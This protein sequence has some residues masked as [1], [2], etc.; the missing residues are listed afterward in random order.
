MKEKNNL[1]IVLCTIPQPL[2]ESSEIPPNIAIV[3]LFNWMEKHGFHGEFYDIDRI[4]PANKSIVKYFKTKKPD[5][6]GISSVLSTCYKNT[7]NISSIIR[8]AVPDALIVLGG[9]MAISASVF[10]QKTEVDIC[11]VGDGEKSWVSLLE[12]AK[13]YGRKINVKMLKEIKGIAF[14]N[15]EKQMEFTGYNTPIPNEEYPSPDYNIL[16]NGS[17]ELLNFYF[18]SGKQFRG[19]KHLEDIDERKPNLAKVQLSRGCVGKC[20]FCQRFC[21]GYHILDLD[22]VEEHLI[23]LKNDYNVGFIT[24]Y[25]E[26]LGADKKH[27][28]KAAEIFDKHNFLWYGSGF[29]CTSINREDLEFYKSKGLTGIKF[30]IESGSQ[31]MLDIMDK[32]FTVD[33]VISTLKD[34]NDLGIYAPVSI[35]IGMPGET[36]KTVRETGEF[37]GNVAKLVGVNPVDLGCGICYATPFPGTP[38]FEYGVLNGAIGGSVEE[39]ERLLLHLSDKSTLKNSFINLTGVSSRKAF[40]WDYLFYL[41]ALRTFYNDHKNCTFNSD[42]EYAWI[43]SSEENIFKKITRVLPK[44]VCAFI[45]TK[46]PRVVMYPVLRNLLYLTFLMSRK[47]KFFKVR[48]KCKPLTNSQALRKTNLVLREEYNCET[49]TEKNQILLYTCK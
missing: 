32:R 44:R 21:K 7:K 41:E 8:D 15:D 16:T 4:K 24:T 1:K 47:N 33:D 17:K 20:S 29:R 10:L 45:F 6:I 26:C 34:A 49:L 38:L 40:F 36:D 43:T 25:D 14:L 12:Y 11:V 37:I 42:T 9:N 13:K 3:S 28:Y 22:N 19:F 35:V 39:D 5:V 48:K 18:R 31:K 27:M 30:G 23:E 46:I 2:R